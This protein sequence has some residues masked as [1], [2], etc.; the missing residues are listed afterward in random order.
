MFTDLKSA[1]RSLSKSPAFALVAVLTLALGLAA[2]TT[3]FSLVNT[4]LLRPLPYPEAQR[5]VSVHEL[6]PKFSSEQLPVNAWHFATWRDSSTSFSDLTL[7]GAS[8]AALTG[9]GEARRIPVAAA[10]HEVFSTLGFVPQ[11]GRLFT[12]D[13]EASGHNQVVVI[14][15]SFWRRELNG[16]ADVIGRKLVLN[17]TPH[18]IIG[19]LPPGAELPDLRKLGPTPP[20]FVRPEILKPMAFT[21]DELARKIGN[22]NYTVIGRLRPAATPQSAQTEL[23]QLAR[24]I[25]Q[26]AGADLELRATVTPLHDAIVQASRRQLWLLLGSVGALLVISCV[27]LASLLLARFEQKRAESALRQALGASRFQILRLALAEPFLIALGGGVLG[28]ILSSYAIALVPQFAP[29]D[30]PR[31]AE[32]GFDGQV[33]LF[34]LSA[35]VLSLVLTGLLPALLLT[36]QMTSAQLAGGRT[37]AGSS[38]VSRNQRVLLTLQV[39]LSVILLSGAGILS[40]SLFR[41]AA[42]DQGFRHP[43]T[44]AAS[45]TAPGGRYATDDDRIAFFNR[46]LAKLG[47][48]PGVISAATCSRLPLQGETWIDRFHVPGD[49]RPAEAQPNA[50]TRF[51]SA[52]YF[53]SIGLHFIAGRTFST[54]E[55]GRNRAI[56]SRSMAEALWPGLDPVGRQIARG[57]DETIEVIGVV[58]DV[59]ANAGAKP[60]PTIYR[61]FTQWPASTMYLVV[62]CAQPA[63]VATPS[64]VN[65]IHSLDPDVPVTSLGTLDTIA[66]QAVAPQRFMANLAIG[67]AV[68]AALLTALGLF[69]VVSY[70]VACRQREF[71]VRL[72]LGATPEELPRQLLRDHMAPVALGLCLGW[73]AYTASSSLLNSL[74]FE[75]NA[76]EPAILLMIG[77]LVGLL[78]LFSA[79]W[80]A[81]RASRVDPMIALRAE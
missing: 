49:T 53:Q 20:V 48:T 1:V 52:D 2:C 75:T 79:W 61:Q 80:P 15:D 23:N 64:L 70:S 41:L 17:L 45:V 4:V 30:L 8:T 19:V 13:D 25:T 47:S 34:A 6:L 3:V 58:D 18:T 31:L 26:D 14:T 22:H 29:S 12:A 21:A 16:A 43:A 62:E 44:I 42:A 72:A 60:V 11:L 32:L 55:Q 59:R 28:L 5:L 27:N 74:L 57:D 37:L 7:F 38:R 24:A 63:A 39:A 81:R 78:A 69:G 35:S 68:A 50:N 54:D 56:I 77:A 67:F 76:R 66:Y 71:G 40:R 36:Q 10:T 51:I 46:L 33:F 65:A 73:L 9:A